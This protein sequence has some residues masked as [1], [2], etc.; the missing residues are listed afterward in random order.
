MTKVRWRVE[1]QSSWSKQIESKRV[2]LVAIAMLLAATTAN[3][4]TIGDGGVSTWK[5]GATAATT[6]TIDD[7]QK[8]DHAWWI[9]TGNT[10]DVNFTWFV[11]TDRIGTAFGG[12]WADYIALQAEGHSIQSHTVDHFPNFPSGA[13]LTLQTN[14]AQAITDIETNVPGSD[15]RT[16]AYPFGLQAPNDKTLAG[17]H[18]IG[19]RGVVGT[20]NKLNG[21]DYMN[22]NSIS[23]TNSGFQYPGSDVGAAWADASQLLTPGNQ[24][25][26][27]W[28]SYH[29]HG[30]NATQ[31]GHV[32]G[33]LDYLTGEPN[34]FW[35][36]PFT[37]VSQ[38][39]QERDAAQLTTQVI[40]ADEIQYTLTDSLDDSLFDQ[41][42]TVKVRVDNSWTQVIATQG[43]ETLPV[44][45][46][47]EGGEQFAIVNSIPDLGVVSLTVPVITGDFDQDEDVD[48]D[49]FLSWQR[50]FGSGTTLGQGDANGNGAVDAVDLVIWN[51]QYGNLPGQTLTSIP[52]PTTAVLGGLFWGLTM[53]SRELRHSR[54]G[55]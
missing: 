50:G 20:P 13:P 1:I 30:V 44:T 42:L 41:P 34:G 35:I 31:R 17:Q 4:A 3:A 40:S 18:Y 9:A 46:V 45:L 2:S 55:N 27:G 10:Y 14:Y 51:Q 49:D 43:S 38:Y 52:E 12:T 54:N 6:I 32:T 48:G 24:Y 25:Y 33:L 26:K 7:N 8:P 22:V 47:Q 37:D 19:A 21:V 23:T 36:A 29:A 11:I 53:L 28:I 5:D 16:L 15:V 39:A